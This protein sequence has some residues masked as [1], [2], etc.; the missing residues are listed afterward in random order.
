MV[1]CQPRLVRS[2]LKSTVLS[3]TKLESDLQST[4]RFAA[5]FARASPLHTHTHAR[6]HI[7]LYYTCGLHTL[8]GT[9][10]KE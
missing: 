5:S 8:H 10:G 6:A 9:A 2:C 1:A 7:L 3:K 4:G